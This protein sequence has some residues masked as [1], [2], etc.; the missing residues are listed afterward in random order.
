MSNICL[1]RTFKL[2]S[3]TRDTLKFG[4]TA[5]NK[6]CRQT[7]KLLDRDG[8]LPLHN[9]LFS[10]SSSTK[11][12]PVTHYGAAAVVASVNS[13]LSTKIHSSSFMDFKVLIDFVSHNSPKV[14]VFF[15]MFLNRC[16]L[17]STVFFW[18]GHQE[19]S[20]ASDKDRHM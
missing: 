16:R 17:V 14:G 11:S 7:S 5:K 8:H 20:Q 9:L 15:N 1:G 19:S 18:T 6:F 13:A 3:Y 12:V 2:T 4:G 10:L